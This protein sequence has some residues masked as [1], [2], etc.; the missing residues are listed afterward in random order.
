MHMAIKT[1]TST[2]EWIYADDL[3]SGSS[4][5][6]LDNI[7][8]NDWYEIQQWILYAVNNVLCFKSS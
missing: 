6:I 1:G 5:T 7:Y 2:M 8:A 3:R 4:W